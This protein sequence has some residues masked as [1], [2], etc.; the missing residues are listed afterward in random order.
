MPATESK[1]AALDFL[2]SGG[3]MGGIITAF[4][5]SAHLPGNPADWPQSLKT[6]VSLIP[7]SQ[8]PMGISVGPVRCARPSDLAL[9]RHA[10][11]S[12]SGSDMAPRGARSPCAHSPLA[13]VK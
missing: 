13:K 6:S 11:Q 1:C 4:D 12:F 10:S 2:S 9:V 8:N 5:W 3:K 7:N